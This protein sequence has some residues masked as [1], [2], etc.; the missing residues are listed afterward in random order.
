MATLSHSAAL[1]ARRG[2]FALI[3]ALVVCNPLVAHAEDIVTKPYPG[4]TH[5]FRKTASQRVHVLKIDLSKKTIRIRATESADRRRTAPS[6]ADLVGC[7]MAINGDF[8]SFEDYSTSGLAM[9]HG[10]QWGDTTDTKGSSYVGFGVDNRVAI[11]AVANTGAPPEWLADAVGGHPMIVSQGQRIDH[12]TTGLGAP[13]P[14]TAAGFSEDK[15]TLILAV[16]DGRSSVAAGMTLNQLGDLMID[17]GA[18]RAL[19]LDGGGSSTMFIRGEGGVVNVPS[20]GSPRVTGNQLAVCVVKAQGD[21]IGYIRE[22]DIYDPEASIAGATVTLSSGETTTTDASGQYRFNDIAAGDVTI[23]ATS[24]ALTGTRSVYVAAADLTWGSIA[25]AEAPAADAM[26]PMADAGTS[27]GSDGG[28]AGADGGI[29]PAGA[30][31]GG[32]PATDSGMTG[33]CHAAPSAT[34][35]AGAGWLALMVVGLVV[36]RRR[37]A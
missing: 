28:P 27:T 5:I 23:T 32:N 12:A 7:E 16:V 6:F 10:T 13:N 25:V 30:D 36:V 19:N 11:P 29:P 33:G 34:T 37:R 2:A 26:P 3:L 21:L 31:G 22:G 14:R 17:M 18:Y 20:D 24:A 8:F 15:K 35:A 9:G 1:R 4:V